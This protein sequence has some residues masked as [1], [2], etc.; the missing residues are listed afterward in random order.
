MIGHGPGTTAPA[1]KTVGRSLLTRVFLPTAALWVAVMGLGFLVVD[2]LAVDESA[3]NEAFVDARTD[4]L[5]GVSTV[6]SRMGDTEVLIA[7]CLLIA[8]FIW[9]RSRQWWFALVPV[10]AL[11]LQALVFITT[12]ALLARPRPEVEHLNHAPPTSSFPSGH[13]G[14]TAAAYLAFALCATRIRNTGLRV[15][16][17]VV[18]VLMPIAM[19][20]SRVYRG[21]H[22]PTDVIMG[23]IV[24]GTCALIAWNWLPMRDAAERV[25]ETD[26]AAVKG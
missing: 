2:V 5:N 23:L 13:T 8:A 10:L 25:I 11:A 6:V 4:T 1:G 18:C 3:I 16:V 24:G 15:T 19:A 9:W 7:T 12:S 17:Q 21:M 22:H 26:G 20:V 14:A